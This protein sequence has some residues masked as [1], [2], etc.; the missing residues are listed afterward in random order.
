[1]RLS[2]QQVVAG[3]APGRP[4]QRLVVDVRFL[5]DRYHGEEWPPS[6][7][8]LFLALVA[9]LY[10]S[11]PGRF[12]RADGDR[13]LQY[14]ESMGP[15]RID[16]VGHEA[17]PYTLFVPNNDWDLVLKDIE[18][19]RAITVNPRKYTTGKRLRPHVA[20]AVR[21]AWEVRQGGA[22]DQGALGLLCRLAREIPVLGWGID[23]VAVDCRVID[24]VSPMGGATEYA[25]ADG[26]ADMKIDVP[27]A[28]LLDDAKRRYKEFAG[29]VTADGF[30]KPGPITRQRSA[31]YKAGRRAA[32]LL[33]FR[34]HSAGKLF[35]APGGVPELTRAVRDLCGSDLGGAKVVPLPT[36]GGRHAD[37]MVRRVGLIVPPS[38]R[39]GALLRKIDSQFVDVGGIGRFQIASV[40]DSDGVRMSYCHKSRV[41]RSVTPLEAGGCGGRDRQ[42]AAD[43]VAREMG[44]RGLQDSLLSIRLDKV[45]DRAGLRRLP[46]AAPLW[47]AEIEFKRALDGPLTAGTGTDRGNGVLAPAQ[48]P[49]VAYYAVLG[50]RPSVADTV[51]VAGAMRDAVTSKAGR[52]RDGWLSPYLSGRDG[53]GRP[54]RDNHAQAYW[55]PVD[56]DRDGLIDHIAVYLKYGIEPSV[57]GAFST[58]TKIPGRGGRSVRVRFAG[59]HRRGDLQDRCV[60]FGR[61][62]R[63][64]T[65]TPY[66]APWH[67]K[68]NCGVA[69]QVKKEARLQKHR[70]AH[71]DASAGR[72]IPAGGGAMPID[73]FEAAHRGKA[74]LNAG[75]HVAIRLAESED[76][77]VLLGTNSHFGLGM[78][79]P[80]GAQRPRRPARAS[81]NL[82]R[83]P[84]IA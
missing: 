5:L 14:L 43:L 75:C 58:L 10:Q 67:K 79:V 8:R 77:P 32:R 55:L 29:Q 60:L 68:R 22:G 4:A 80:D 84:A 50:R 48:M 17:S 2:R 30:I 51:A 41:W 23:P 72:A 45:P 11:P 52:L 54:L 44:A 83:G 9:A 82:G 16:A 56:N 63:W 74:P 47:Y 70:V 78:F 25:P 21:Y 28:G 12:A 15:P 73:S 35:V 40:P 18:K 66:F 31:G 20:T 71:V 61:G 37:G 13:A 33:A 27:A 34:L 7:R 39:A 64:V 3:A 81:R 42:G 19:N 1:M 49:D 62:T 69:E 26:G 53:R 76:G 57:R 59:F 46:G 38:A 36:I 65:A 6:P 24:A